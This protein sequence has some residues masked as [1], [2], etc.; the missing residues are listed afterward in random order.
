MFENRDL[1]VKTISTIDEME[2]EI[3][4][5]KQ[6]NEMLKSK[7]DDTEYS[8]YNT[9]KTNENNMCKLYIAYELDCF[10]VAINNSTINAVYGLYLKYDYITLNELINYICEFAEKNNIE[11]INELDFEEFKNWFYFV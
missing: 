8:L 10:D 3:K 9:M 11:D 4:R 7:C 6:E 1:P 2:N 5:L